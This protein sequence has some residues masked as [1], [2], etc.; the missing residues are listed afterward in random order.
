MV[1]Q[2]SGLKGF[3]ANSTPVPTKT[4]LRRQMLPVANLTLDGKRQVANFQNLKAQCGFKLAELVET[5]RIVAK[6]GGDMDEIVEDFSQIKQKDV[7]KEEASGSSQDA[8][9]LR[10][11]L[12]GLESVS[13]R[14]GGGA[15]TMDS[16]RLAIAAF[17]RG[18]WG[19]SIR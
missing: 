9:A 17:A 18:S 2:L 14:K 8:E 7:E 5:H 15:I 12:E 16:V 10:R 11:H 1:D 19:S 4:M 6:P 13:R 3:I